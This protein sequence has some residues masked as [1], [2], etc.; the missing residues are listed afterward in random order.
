MR[1]ALF[2]T[3]VTDTLY[4]GTGRAALAVLER[5]GVEVDFPLA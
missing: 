3:C 2:V 4:P 1:V 5:L